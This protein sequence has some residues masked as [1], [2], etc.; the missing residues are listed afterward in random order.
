MVCTPL[1]M[2]ETEEL[3]LK[4]GMSCHKPGSENVTGRAPSASPSIT[5]GSGVLT[6]LQ[7]NEFPGACMGG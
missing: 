4:D 5:G 3:G 1:R 7:G 2:E 6:M